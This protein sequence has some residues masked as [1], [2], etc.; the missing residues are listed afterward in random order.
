MNIKKPNQ[1]MQ[2]HNM[3]QAPVQLVDSRD[4]HTTIFYICL[5]EQKTRCVFVL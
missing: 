2:I 4:L 1:L 3:D 5:E